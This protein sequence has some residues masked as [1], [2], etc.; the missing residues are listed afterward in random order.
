MS[1]D[2]KQ[3]GGTHYKKCPPEF[4]HWNLVRVHGW[5]YFQA[6][7]IKYIMRY[8]EKNGKEDLKKALHFVEK[9]IET[10]EWKDK[11]VIKDELHYESFPLGVVRVE[12]PDYYH[13]VK[14]TGWVGFTYEGGDAKGD[15][16]TCVNCRKAVH[17]KQCQP[18]WDVHNALDCALKAA[19]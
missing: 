14:P 15:L 8:K 5:D 10:E 6:Q 9:M 12:R 13:Y 7:A 4:Q 16:Y 17:V 2:T 18:P 19:M 1:V 11:P 3:E